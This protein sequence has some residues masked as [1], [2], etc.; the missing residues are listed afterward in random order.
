MLI[1]SSMEHQPNEHAKELAPRALARR[2]E[3]HWSVME[4]ALA[5][6]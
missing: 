6:S 1:V 2:I 4:R 5:G 3:A